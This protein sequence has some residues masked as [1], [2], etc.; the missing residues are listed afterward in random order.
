METIDEKLDQKIQN[1]DNKIK[2]DI[3]EKAKAMTEEG[4]D[5]CAIRVVIDDFYAANAHLGTDTP[6]PAGCVAPQ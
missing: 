5:V 1:I 6:Y 4:E 2:L 3:A